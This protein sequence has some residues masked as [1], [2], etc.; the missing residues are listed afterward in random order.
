LPSA[1]PDSEGVGWRDW[2]GVLPHQDVAG[3][4]AVSNGT[5]CGSILSPQTMLPRSAPIRF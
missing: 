1:A 5:I 4:P 3:L 2:I